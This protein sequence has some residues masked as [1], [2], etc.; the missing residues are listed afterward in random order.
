MD[1]EKKGLGAFLSKNFDAISK[2]FVY[3]IAMCVFGVV[4]VLA[5]QMLTEQIKGDTDIPL[6]VPTYI[7]SVVAVLIYLGLIYVCMWEKGASDRI[8]ILGGR[9]KS[10]LYK[11]L[12]FWLVANAI[13]IVVILCV[14]VLHFIPSASSTHGIFSFL[15]LLFNAMY[16]PFFS[17]TSNISWIYFIVLIPGAVMALI[18]YILGVSGYKCIFPEPKGEKNRKLK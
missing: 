14:C 18:S 12:L 17:L 13:N 3:H 4:V 1:E 5:V 2:L 6:G 11:G 10:N 15:A 9:M 7:A 16:T 8:K